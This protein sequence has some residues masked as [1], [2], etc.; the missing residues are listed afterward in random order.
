MII[1]Q[2]LQLLQCFVTG[3]STKTEVDMFSSPTAASYKLATLGTPK[4]LAKEIICAY[5]CMGTENCAAFDYIGSTCTLLRYDSS[6]TYTAT[7]TLKLRTN[8]VV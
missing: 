2:A 8:S 4:T 3:V 7:Q 1:R 5:D 6:T